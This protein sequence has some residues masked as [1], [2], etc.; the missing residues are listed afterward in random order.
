MEIV[1][2]PFFFIFENNAGTDLL[3]YLGD[4]LLQVQVSLSARDC[5]HEPLGIQKFLSALAIQLVKFQCQMYQPHL[6][7]ALLE[8]LLRLSEPENVNPKIACLQQEEG[9]TVC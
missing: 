2:G 6:E 7:A 8:H 3:F 9:N 4:F 5:R 1:T